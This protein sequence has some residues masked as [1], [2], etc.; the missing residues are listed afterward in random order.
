[1]T[2]PTGIQPFGPNRVPLLSGLSSVD[3]AT[4]VPIA[5]DPVTGAILT[6]TVVTPAELPVALIN[7]QQTATTSA[8]ALPAGVLDV[9]VILGGL[10]TNTVSIFVGGAGVTTA[11]GIELQPGA[12]VSAAINNTNKIYIIC[13]SGSPVVTWLGS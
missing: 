5:V 8:V 1:M 11:T 4:A 2:W 3:N 9:G 13:A 10:S 6:E 12:S 7:N